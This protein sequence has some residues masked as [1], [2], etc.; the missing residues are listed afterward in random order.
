MANSG[1]TLENRFNK[2]NLEMIYLT[3]SFERFFSGKDTIPPVIKLKQYKTKIKA[4]TQE[5]YKDNALKFKVNN[6]YQKFLAYEAN[7]NKKLYLKEVGLTDN[8]K[9]LSSKPN[10]SYLRKSR[11]DQLYKDFLASQKKVSGKAIEK[12]KFIAHIKAQKKKLE[13]QNNVNDI[14]FKIIIKDGKTT[15]KAYR[16]NA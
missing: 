15:V 1:E 2:L 12:E 14:W 16:E 5:K 9:K 7:W 6:L 3:Q 10:K 13:K 11:E 8:G 4:L